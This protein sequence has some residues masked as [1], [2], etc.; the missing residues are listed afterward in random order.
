MAIQLD[1]HYPLSPRELFEIYTDKAFYEKRYAGAG[2]DQYTF[3][4]FTPKTDGFEI[5]IEINPP[6]EIPDG[7]PKAARKLVPERQR[8]KYSAI[9]TIHDDD[10]MVAEYTYDVQGKPIVVAGSRTLRGEKAGTRNIGAFDI[11]CSIP[12]FGGLLASLLEDRV[13]REM[14]ADEVAVQEYIRQMG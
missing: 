10:H 8:T 12:V 5:F 14:E 1:N 3:E 13:R 7:V 11:E 2:V 9:W 6:I 4:A